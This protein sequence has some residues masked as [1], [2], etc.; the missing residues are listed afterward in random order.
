M[1]FDAVFG[2]LRVKSMPASPAL[3]NSS[4]FRIFL[5]SMN[6]E[7]FGKYFMSTESTKR[8]RIVDRKWT[9]RNFLK[10]LVLFFIFLFVTF[11]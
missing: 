7:E 10:M 1:M 11:W 8:K 5:Y 9:E 2:R 6:L 3:F 4:I